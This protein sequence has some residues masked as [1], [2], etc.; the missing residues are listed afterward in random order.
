MSRYRIA[1]HTTGQVHV[2]GKDLCIGE[3]IIVHEYLP[4]EPLHVRARFY[5]KYFSTSEFP[6]RLTEYYS[7][8]LSRFPHEKRQARNN[9]T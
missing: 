8:L 9:R 3:N 6:A 7:V 2:A 1:V 4:V 5:N